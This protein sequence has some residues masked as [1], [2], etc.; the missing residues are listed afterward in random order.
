MCADRTR[1]TGKTHVAAAYARSWIET[2]RG[3]SGWVNAETIDVAVTDLARIAEAIGV[4]DPEGDSA[5]SARRLVDH[6]ATRSGES[7]LVFDNATDPD[8]L[9]VYLPTVGRTRVVITTTDAAFAEFG[10]M[11]ELEQFTRAESLQYLADR[12]GISD[13]AGAEVLAGELGDLPLALAAATSTIRQR[14]HRDYSR[15]LDQLRAYPV[16]QVL[17][18]PPGQDYRRSTAAALMLSMD[19][20]ARDDPTGLASRLTGIMS[21]MPPTGSASMFCRPSTL[22]L[23]VIPA[24]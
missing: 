21:V 1:G 3:W 24:P 13:A 8:A 7:L 19:S 14:R 17:H 23:L 18:R 4:A 12:T 16:E 5:T 15:Y 6:L 10:D 11:V 22:R 20:L 2:G 9:R